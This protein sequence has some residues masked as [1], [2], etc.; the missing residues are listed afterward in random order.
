IDGYEQLGFLHR[1][2][3]SR[4]CRRLH[5]GLLVTAH[6][7]RR[8]N[9]IPIIFRTQSDLATMQFLVDRVLPAHG[10]VVRPDDV[11]AEFTRHGGNVREA[12]FSL[13]DLFQKRC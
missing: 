11:A 6:E 4:M 9:R 12:F 2:R 5:W 1:W 8:V 7:D 10:G 3:L 13:Y